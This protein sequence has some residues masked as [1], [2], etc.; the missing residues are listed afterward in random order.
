MFTCEK[1]GK[2]FRYKSS[3]ER[4]IN[5]KR[6]CI[7][8]KKIYRCHKCNYETTHKGTFDRH[9]KMK[10]DCS[11]YKKININI[12]DMQNI[13][14]TFLI[15]TNIIKTD[16]YVDLS[17]KP[18]EELDNYI[19]NIDTETDTSEIAK[20]DEFIYII[21]EREFIKTNESIYKIG[22]TKK[23]LR[24]RMNGYPK[25]SKVLYFTKVDDC[26]IIESKMITTFDTIFD[27]A[28]DIGREY[29]SGNIDDMIK[30]ANMIVNKSN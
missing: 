19:N 8:E 10:R 25:N 26:S 3:Y 17:G 30:I 27:N 11:K 20:D 6:S 29:Y 12:D 16:N 5:C 15:N 7:A 4:H 22:K 21:Q 24:T 23:D 1:C 9:V 28:K 13:L 14:Q 2:D 18:N